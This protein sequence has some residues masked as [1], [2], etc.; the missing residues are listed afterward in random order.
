[1]W[2]AS[3]KSRKIATICVWMDGSLTWTE[4]IAKIL[5][6]NT[7]M[8]S[9]KEKKIYRNLMPS[10]FG[11]SFCLFSNQVHS[12]ST[13]R[14]VFVWYG[15]SFGIHHLF[16][17]GESYLNA[18][19]NT[20]NRNVSIVCYSLLDCAT[21]SRGVLSQFKFTKYRYLVLFSE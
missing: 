13:I 20:H 2:N 21:I 5:T 8:S 15:I 3:I 7:A 14:C 10:I 18:P 12:Q 11:C 19:L 1:M 9:T 17:N 4:A 16:R 6:L